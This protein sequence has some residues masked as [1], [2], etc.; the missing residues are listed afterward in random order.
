[1]INLLRL[2]VMFAVGLTAWGLTF[3][4]SLAWHTQR[5]GWLCCVVMLDEMLGITA[6]MWLARNG[7][8]LEGAACALGGMIAA[9]LMLRWNTEE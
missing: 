3:G 6:G 7:T 2:F 8:Y 1:M 5:R 9:W 4:R